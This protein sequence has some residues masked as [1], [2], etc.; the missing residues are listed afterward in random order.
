MANLKHQEIIETRPDGSVRTKDKKRGEFHL[1]DNMAEAEDFEN[2]L[3]N[4]KD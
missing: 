4:I 1:F 2:E 3:E